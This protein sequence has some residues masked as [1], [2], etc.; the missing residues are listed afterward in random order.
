VPTHTQ[1][2]THTD[3]QTHTHTQ[4]HRHTDT[5]THLDDLVQLAERIRVRKRAVVDHGRHTHSAA[6]GNQ[7]G[8]RVLNVVADTHTPLVVADEEVLVVFV[9]PGGGQSSTTPWGSRVMRSENCW[10]SGTEREKEEEERSH[11]EMEKEIEDT[12]TH[13]QRLKHRT[14][15]SLM[16]SWRRLVPEKSINPPA[17]CRASRMPRATRRSEWFGLLSAIDLQTS[18]FL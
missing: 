1:T 9:K 8:D 17:A 13:M 14:H 3:I 12:H 10:D 2:Q 15:P 4:T 16:D 7:N 6:E 5:H 18:V 11:R